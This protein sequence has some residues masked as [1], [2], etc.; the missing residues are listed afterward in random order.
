MSTYTR[1]NKKLIYAQIDVP[2]LLPEPADMEDFHFTHRALNK[3]YEDIIQNR[4]EYTVA[5]SRYNINDWRILPTAQYMNKKEWKESS[6]EYKLNWSPEFVKRFPTLV[7]AILAAPF[8]EIAFAGWM[9]QINHY[10]LH[11]DSYDQ[12]EPTEPR[13]YNI[14]LTEP[15]H[16]TFFM[17]DGNG[18]EIRPDSSKDYPM[19][20]FN[21]VDVMHGTKPITKFKLMM[22]IVGIVDEDRHLKL[23][24][25]SVEK[26]PDKAIWI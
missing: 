12:T 21:N 14:L 23:L 24:E 11:R 19:F 26:F 8:K 6:T 3:D 13:R 9:R 16:N 7:D 10:P 5:C 22:G 15:E 18:G 4:H 25:R 17:E 2:I 1:N 20:A